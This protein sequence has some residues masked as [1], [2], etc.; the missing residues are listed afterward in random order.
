MRR[1]ERYRFFLKPRH[2]GLLIIFT[3]SLLIAFWLHHNFDPNFFTKENLQP[4][5]FQAGWFAPFIYISILIVSVVISHI[6]AVP[7][8]MLSGMVWNPF[9]ATFYSVMGGFLGALCAYFLGRSLGRNT[10]KILTGKVVH[11]SKDKGEIYIGFLI[12][13][14]RL[15][16][17][18]SF[19]LISYGSGFAGISLPIYATTTLTGMIPPTF[20]LTYMGSSLALNSYQRV[21]MITFLL[22]SSITFIWLINRYNLFG[23]KDIIHFE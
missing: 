21:G 16:P 4:I 17:L 14:T 3:A 23:L 18:F 22:L 1:T 9:L 2:Q 15:V 12:F 10:L 19:D 20:L 5:L 6:P 13:I 7:L 8:V 11:I